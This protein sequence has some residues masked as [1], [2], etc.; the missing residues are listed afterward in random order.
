MVIRKG[1]GGNSPVLYFRLLPPNIPH[2]REAGSRLHCRH[3]PKNACALRELIRKQGPASI[4]RM[5]D[6]E[7][8]FLV[9]GKGLVK[10]RAQIHVV[11][12]QHSRRGRR[13]EDRG[14]SYWKSM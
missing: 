10:N 2:T 12:N 4:E 6:Q 8:W 14:I 1:F 11:L 5:N 7:T 13:E 9:C 3:A